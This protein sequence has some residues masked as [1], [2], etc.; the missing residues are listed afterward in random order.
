MDLSPV[1]HPSASLPW[2][3]AQLDKHNPQPCAMRQTLYTSTPKL[4]NPPVRS[5]GQNMARRTRDGTSSRNTD[6]TSYRSR[7]ST[8]KSILCPYHSLLFRSP[9]TPLC[10][11]SKPQTNVITA[12]IAASQ[13]ADLE[14]SASAPDKLVVL[15][16]R[17]KPICE[18][19]KQLLEFTSGTSFGSANV[20][21]TH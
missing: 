8:A 9:Q 4:W 21:S 7:T 20:I 2:E 1:Q 3:R 15:K 6:Q 14:K 16:T 10:S 5:D 17:L 11:H 12:G 18:E 19:L 13:V